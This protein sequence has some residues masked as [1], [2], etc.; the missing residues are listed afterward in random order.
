[1]TR[2]TLM[3]LL[4]LVLLTGCGV[5]G[6]ILEDMLLAEVTGYDDAGDDKVRG[7]VVVS[8]SQSGE[9][10]TMG[11][12]VFT[13]VTHT[14]KNVRQ[15]IES[16]ATKRLVGGRLQ[17][18]LYG[19]S[20]ARKGI[21][22][23]VDT[24][25]RDPDVGRDLYLAVV[26]GKAEDIVNIESKMLKTPD[27]KTKELIQQNIQTNLPDIN[28]HSFLYYYYGNNMDPVMPLLEKKQDHIKVKGIALFK[29]DKYI[30]KY[31]TYED[32][33]LF[34]VLFGNFRD[35]LYEMK[36][37]EDS[38]INIQNISSNVKYEI[39]DG[40]GS[41]KVT[42]K[43]TIKGGLLEVQG[44][45]LK[46]RSAIPKIEKKAQ[47]VFERELGRMVEMFQ[48]NNVDPLALGDRARSKTR[49]FDRENWERVYPTIPVKVKVDVTLVQEGITE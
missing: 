6:N 29:D 9:N 7:S 31:I 12:E 41:P 30:G 44:V 20:L 37:K 10:S 48:E 21:Y 11:K 39:E 23:Y 2:K 25:R 40:N 38:Y 42:I 49:N 14:G 27:V 15:R 46:N 26:S 22:D 33:F 8:I 24:Y 45:D 47:K 1:M 32:G 4:S 28:L 34:K 19:E 3:L 13:T 16:E 5:K 36:M 35:G 43:A 18:I 17:A